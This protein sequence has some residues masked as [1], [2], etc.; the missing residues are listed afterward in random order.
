MFYYIRQSAYF[1]KLLLSFELFSTTYFNMGFATSK[2]QTNVHNI[3]QNSLRS[4]S[5]LFQE[6]ILTVYFVYLLIVSK[7]LKNH[8][9]PREHINSILC[10]ALNS[11]EVLE[12]TYTSPS[13]FY[14]NAIY[15]NCSAVCSC[16]VN[17]SILFL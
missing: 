8:T 5:S 12:N 7:S 2:S 16:L 6:T 15:N 11:F 10:I 3:I 1:R 17:Q 4:P 13:Y 14:K 9:F